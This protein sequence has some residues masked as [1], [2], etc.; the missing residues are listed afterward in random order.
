MGWLG[1]GGIIPCSPAG[2]GRQQG[3]RRSM[4]SRVAWGFAAVA[5]LFAGCVS[6]R[7]EVD[8]HYAILKKPPGG[9]IQ[10]I[11]KG[12]SQQMSS[13]EGGGAIVPGVGRIDL[14]SRRVTATTAAFEATFPDAS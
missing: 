3:E 13:G 7:Y 1:Y 2:V 14:R 8:C 4:K 9:A 5:W 6:K 11:D 10:V 12:S